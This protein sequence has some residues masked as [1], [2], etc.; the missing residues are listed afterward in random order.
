MS[1]TALSTSSRDDVEHLQGTGRM[2]IR[3]EEKRTDIPGSRISNGYMVYTDTF[4]NTIFV[5]RVAWRN[6]PS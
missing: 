2:K 5:D 6:R 3:T 4:V 1:E